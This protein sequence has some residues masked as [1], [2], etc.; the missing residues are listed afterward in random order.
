MIGAMTSPLSPKRAAYLRRLNGAA[1]ERLDTQIA[2][3]AEKA[4]ARA[5]ARAARAPKPQAPAVVYFLDVQRLRQIGALQ[6]DWKIIERPAGL[7]MVDRI[8]AAR[9]RL[10]IF[11]EAQAVPI[12]VA[13]SWWRAGGHDLAGALCPSCGKRSRRLY[14]IRATCACRRCAFGAGANAVSRNSIHL[15]RLKGAI[16]RNLTAPAL[17]PTEER[18]R[19]RCERPFPAAGHTFEGIGLKKHRLHFAAQVPELPK[20]YVGFPQLKRPPAS[21]RMR[22]SSTYRGNTPHSG[23][24]NFDILSRHFAILAQC[25]KLWPCRKAQK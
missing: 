18:P 9:H 1:L 2:A 12:S 15:V 6:G 16:R 19:A 23:A 4:R 25:A 21:N 17:G 8:V 22:L 20:T 24:Q 11:L 10:Q 14:F 5:A 3:Q 7:P 13:L